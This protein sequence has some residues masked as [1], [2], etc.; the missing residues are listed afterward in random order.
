MI[1]NDVIVNDIIINRISMISFTMTIMIM[2]NS[3][4]IRSK[5]IKIFEQKKKSNKIDAKETRVRTIDVTYG[6]FKYRTFESLETK[7]SLFALERVR[8]S[9]ACRSCKDLIK[10][11]RNGGKRRKKEGT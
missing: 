8:R 4:I 6:I 9:C 3:I 10:K 5:L 7:S 2:K 1:I 11:R